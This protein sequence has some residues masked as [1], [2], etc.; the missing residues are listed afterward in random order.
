[1][2][3]LS[4]VAGIAFL[5]SHIPLVIPGWP[6]ARAVATVVPRGLA[7]RGLLLVDL[8]LVAVAGRRVLR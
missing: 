3:A 1:L 7:E 6:G 5:V 8:A 4:V 2:T